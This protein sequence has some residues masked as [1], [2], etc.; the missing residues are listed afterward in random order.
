MTPRNLLLQGA[1]ATVSLLGWLILTREGVFGTGRQ[2]TAGEGMALLTIAALYGWWLS[3]VAALTSGVKGAALALVVI[4]V[5][6]VVTAPLAGFAF[7]PIPACTSAAPLSYVSVIFGA[8]AAW[9]AWRAYR[10][11]P[12]PTQWAPAVTA[13]VLIVL[14][15]AFQGANTKFPPPGV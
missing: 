3:P 7:C 8:L 15:F 4:D 5:L 12:G 6:W 2:V 13:V 10:A 1:A 11:M 14:S 9:T